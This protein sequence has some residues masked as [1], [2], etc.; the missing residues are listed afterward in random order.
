ML[1]LS[2]M[3]A[4]YSVDTLLERSKLE[5]IYFANMTSSDQYISSPLLWKVHFFPSLVDL[6]I[7]RRIC[8]RLH[9]LIQALLTITHGAEF[10]LRSW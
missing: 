9:D 8:F 4:K 1:N 6:S 3:N 10:I 7:C 5:G 2:I